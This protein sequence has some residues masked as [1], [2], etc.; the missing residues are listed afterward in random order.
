MQRMSAQPP[1]T[2]VG[3]QIESL[4]R[5]AIHQFDLITQNKKIGIALSGGKD[6]LTLL[7]MLKAMS[8]RGL[9]PYEIE[10]FHVSGAFSCGASIAEKSIKNACEDVGVPL[11]ILYSDQKLE[12][13]ECYSCSRERRR[14]IFH[15]AK[16]LGMETIAFGHHK[17]D[18]VQTLLMNL[19]HTASFEGMLP[20][21]PMLRYGVTIIRP[22]ILVSESLIL[23]FSKQ[24]GFLRVMCQC[25][26]GQV[27]KR[28]STKDLLKD[29]EREFPNAI[30]NLSES[31][32]KFG[33]KKALHPKMDTPVFPLGVTEPS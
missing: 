15:K 21:V 30:D 31:S 7:Y 18:N 1:W 13:L 19:L 17:E 23:R 25:P 22:L 33:T 11:H 9:F 28:R 5:K 24:Y 16:E 10:A 27:S 12:K 20:K 26:V 14:L 2:Q 29:L 32:F 3:R 8:G 6:S 4:I